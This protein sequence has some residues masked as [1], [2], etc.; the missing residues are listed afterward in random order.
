MYV[1]YQ[2]LLVTRDSARKWKAVSPDLTT[3]T[4]D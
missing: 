2:C 4:A 1:G 3:A